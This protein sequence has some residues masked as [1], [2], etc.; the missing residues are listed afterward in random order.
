MQL[1]DSTKYVCPYFWVQ[2]YNVLVYEV[3]KY[4]SY[5]NMFSSG[6]NGT[7]WVSLWVSNGKESATKLNSSGVMLW[8][9][10][11]AMARAFL[12][13]LM[14]KNSKYSRQSASPPYVGRDEHKDD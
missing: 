5:L 9:Q 3:I 11:A 6:I 1:N 7:W 14:L 2:F 10:L 4:D 12:W 8:Q 13:A